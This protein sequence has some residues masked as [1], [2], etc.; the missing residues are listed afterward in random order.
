MSQRWCEL[1][2]A[3]SRHHR[4]RQNFIMNAGIVQHIS[5]KTQSLLRSESWT[6]SATSRAG[7]YGNVCCPNLLFLLMPTSAGGRRL[8]RWDEEKRCE[9]FVVHVWTFE[10]SK[11]WGFH[12][13]GKLETWIL[14]HAVIPYPSALFQDVVGFQVFQF[15]LC[16]MKGETEVTIGA[17]KFGCPGCVRHP[18]S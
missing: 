4:G 12:R 8:G 9:R 14:S 7:G 1:S 11:C 3:L 13:E 10:I 5:R 6:T 17:G 16:F 2:L 18:F 15:W